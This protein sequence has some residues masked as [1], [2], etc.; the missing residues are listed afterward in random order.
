VRLELSSLLVALVVCSTAIAVVAMGIAL[1]YR[2]LLGI[3]YAV[4]PYCRPPRPRLVLVVSGNRAG[5]D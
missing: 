1:A 2:S 3:L 4:A 5:G